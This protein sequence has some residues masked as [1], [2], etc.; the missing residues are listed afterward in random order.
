MTDSEAVQ[1]YVD[2]AWPV[3]S[4]TREGAYR[5]AWAESH[6]P[7]GLEEFK[8]ALSELEWLPVKVDEFWFLQFR[9][10]KAQS[11]RCEGL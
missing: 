6:L 1:A 10:G 3:F 8:A 7:I 2:S 5:R 11:I 9:N 4:L